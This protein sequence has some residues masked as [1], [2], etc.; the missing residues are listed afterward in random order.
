M[1]FIEEL[2]KETN[3]AETAN[4]AVT[5]KSTLS[6]TLDFF[7]MAG[8]MR[9]CLE[10]AAVLFEKAFQ[11]NPLVALR[12]LFYI[13][14]V[15]GGQGEREVFRMCLRSLNRLSPETYKHVIERDYIGEYGRYDDLFAVQSDTALELVAKFVKDQLS[16]DE[17]AMEKGEPVSLLAKWLPSENASSRYTIRLATKLRTLLGLSP[18]QYRRKLTALRNYITLLESKMSHNQWKDITYSKLPSQALMRH[19]VA[20]R[21][22]DS[23]GFQKYLDDVKSGKKSINTN[24]LFTYEIYDLVRRDEEAA[25]VAWSN[26]PDYTNGTNA[27]VVADVSGSM[28]GRP[29]SVSVSLALYFAERNKGAFKNKFMTFSRAPQLIEVEGNTLRDRMRS[30]ERAD[31]SMSTDLA[32][33]FDTIL[34]AAKSANASQ[35]ELP[36]VL[37]II[38]DMEFDEVTNSGLTLFEDAKKK[39]EESGYKLPHVVFWSVNSYGNNVPALAKDDNVT[40]VSGSNQTAFKF[41]V[42]GLTPEEFMCSVVDGERYSRIEL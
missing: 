35:P 30:I 28:D 15:R 33:V 12:S 5:N 2:K 37:Y 36:A 6:A 42:D 1:S 34:Q 31:W 20:F 25:N 39:F 40:L 16:E 14:D 11:A 27:L 23:D 29:M 13:R 19:T 32:K 10:R 18:K 9:Y 17:A 24:T 3:K 22:H 41:A 38:S 4:G 8:G 26:L 21:R 7:S